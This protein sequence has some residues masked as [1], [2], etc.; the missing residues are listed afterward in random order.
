MPVTHG[1]NDMGI[2]KIA[3]AVAISATAVLAPVMTAAPAN[4]AYNCTTWKT[5]RLGAR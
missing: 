5:A 2:K 4:A 3:A 1:R